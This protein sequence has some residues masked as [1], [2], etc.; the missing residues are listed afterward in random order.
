MNYVVFDIETTEPVGP[1]E[2]TDMNI[3]VVSVYSSADDSMQSFLEK[4]FGKMWKIFEE[5]DAIVGYNS[6]HFDIPILN[7]YYSGDLSQIKSIDI[8]KYIKESYGRRVK[9]DDI[10]AATLGTKKS[11]H[12]LQAVKWWQEGK[13]AEIIQ[14]CED[15]VRITKDVFF[16]ALNNGFLKLKDFKGETVQIPIKTDTWGEKEDAS[17][18][19]SM[20]F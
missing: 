2:L 9:L 15:D 4:D 10:A 17:V 14:Y 3:S 1:G 19:F 20:G 16:F 18:T 11:S 13:I 8:L 12:G 5:A 6:E 7:K